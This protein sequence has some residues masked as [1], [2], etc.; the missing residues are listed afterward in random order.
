[1][2]QRITLTLLLLGSFAV[3]KAQNY[4]IKGSLQGQGNEKIILRGIDGPITVEAKENVFELT[5]TAGDE[6]FVT[7]INTSV[8]RNLYLGGGKSGMYQPSLP[9]EVVLT[10]GAKLNITGTALGINMASVTGDA[11]NESFTQFRKAEEKYILEQ[12]ALQKQMVEARVM[13]IPDAMKEIGPKMLENRKAMMAS[14]KKFI[15]DNPEAFASL[16][17]LSTTSRDYTSDELDAAYKG[18]ASTYKSTRY[19]KGIVEKIA[20]L[21]LIQAGGPA[22]DF[23]KLDINGKPVSLSQFKGKYVLLDFWGSWCGPCRAANPHLKELYSTYSS[24]GFEIL[25]I[26]SEKVS[27]QEQAE[28]MW[29]EAVEKD[30]LT[31]TNVINNEKEMK[32]D[33]VRLYDIEG[34]PTQILLDKDGKIVARWLGAGGKAL[35]DKL[36]TIFN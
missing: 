23:T 27:G 5:G 34:Y 35:D 15:K 22:P 30:G 9:L 16:Y 14:R 29:K 10:K 26:S 6:P 13:G 19:A 31:W 20:S 25:G 17:Y 7:S 36:K 1:M 4:V 21:K 32:Q 24:K 33:V 3:S 8:D 2:K 28:K 12:V 11:L 18:L